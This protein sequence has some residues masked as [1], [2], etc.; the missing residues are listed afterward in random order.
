ML[1]SIEYKVWY[2]MSSK[3]IQIIFLAQYITSTATLVTTARGYS[4]RSGYNFIANS[5]W[6]S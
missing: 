2:F 6:L 3:D 5:L 1:F 4:N